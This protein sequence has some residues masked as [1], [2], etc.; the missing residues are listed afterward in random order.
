MLGTM[1]G[2]T[3]SHYRILQKLGGGG[4]GVVYEAEDLKLGRRVALKFLPDELAHDPGSLERFQREARAAS[5]LNHPNICTVYEIDEADGRPFIAMER[6]DGETLKHCISG[7]ALPIEQ[8]PE[9]GIEIAD[10]LDAAHAQGIVHRDI[11]PANIFVTTRGHAKVLDF[12]LAKLTGRQSAADAVGAS[13]P[14]I[15]HEHLTSPGTAVGTIAYMSPEQ[16]LGKALDGR[17][18]LF[19]FGAVLYEMCTGRPP[20]SGDTSAAVFDAILHKTPP[21][22]VRLNPDLP[23]DLERIISKALEK[24]LDLRYQ[25]AADIRADL[26]RLKRDASSSSTLSAAQ[27]PPKTGRAPLIATAVAVLVL[28][29]AGFFLYRSKTAPP[30]APAPPAPVATAA[31]MRTIAVLPF[32]NLSGQKG[33]DIWGVGMADAI[34]SRLASLQ[35]LAVRPTNSVLKYAAGADDP[36]QAA[37]ELQ[38]DS[39]LAGNYQTIGGVMRVSVQLIDHGATRWGSRYDLRSPDMLKFQDDVAQKVVE[40]LSVQLS[41]AEQERM[42]APMTSSPEAYN[43]LVEARAY[44]NQYFVNSRAESLQEGRR[45]IQRAVAKDPSFADAYALLARLYLMEAANFTENGE[46]N[47][48]A[49]EQAA[50]TAVSLQPSS[51][52]ANMALGAVLN[53]R[54]KSTEAI[55]TLRQAV[56]LAPNSVDA[57]DHLGYSYHYAGLIDLAEEAYRRCRDMNPSTP[58][59]Y[60]MHGRML[61]YQG[62]AHEA[63]DEVRQAL[64]RTPDQFKLMAFLGAFLYYEGKPEEAEPVINRAVQLRGGHGD[65]SPVV[66]SAYLHAA[67][68]EREQIDPA[69]L[70]NRPADVID[71][72]YAEWLAGVYALLGD[73]PK[74]L[75]WLKRAVALGDH[76]YPWFQR[77]KNFNSLRGDPEFERL[78]R[79]V[80]GYWKQY[81][82]EF[83]SR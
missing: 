41:G 17:S 1:L 57:L 49:S 62:K 24:D 65:D 29:I 19:S 26:K 4:M 66:F 3:V 67:R 2:Q 18:D 53:E 82:A 69:L 70:R 40:G 39:V 20:F 64:K 75:A 22:P 61:L 58:R 15:S 54:G 33:S 25:N 72:D 68:G 27:P 16:A 21:S 36:A 80:E 28:A 12:G 47:I 73:K 30:A 11:K 14:T 5:A 31:T 45:L 77:D 74:A 52:E 60:W 35:N 63:T 71:G 7:K 55:T 48:L 23:L 43:L 81:T 51:F 76:N 13:S 34:I 44:L 83:G 10:A 38:V 42:R 78:M 37:R 46:R 50:R 6:L 32:H 56:A 9:L 8:V 59:I 79:E